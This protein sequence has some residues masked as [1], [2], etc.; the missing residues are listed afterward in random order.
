METNLPSESLL[1]VRDLGV[2][3]GN[4]RI[5]VLSG[6][7]FQLGAG[8]TLG[9]VG[10]SGCGKST[11]AMALVQLLAGGARLTGGR[12]DFD[13]QELTALPEKAL[14]R[15][16]GKDIA[17]I[18]QDP[19]SSLNPLLRIGTQ[20]AEVPRRH[21]GMDGRS[22]WRRA[23]ELLTSVRL[24]EPEARLKEYP[25]QLSGGMRQRVAGAIALAAMPKLL[26]ADEPTTALDPTVQIQYL[27][28]LKE[29]QREHGFA[30]ILITHDL[31][32]VAH[33]CDEVAVMYA[34]R[35][36][37]HGPT[38]EIFSR[39]AHPYTQALLDSLPRPGARAGDLQ[40]IGGQPPNPGRLPPGC[41]FNP[42]CPR[43]MD[44]CRVQ[45]PVLAPLPD[46]E[47]TVQAACWLHQ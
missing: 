44:K 47:S 9:I 27:K 31:G 46:T 32:I 3:Y 21:L 10:E 14:R 1:S 20:V 34:G 28:L 13:G 40:V 5:P 41:A 7:S 42:R 2:A 16:R 30:L 18:L 29:L 22:A 4:G 15:I 17:M 19:L 12:I 39:P 35:I 24:A 25:H 23:L 6:V 11:L 43:S 8:R 45:V 33:V 37:E 38:A 26:I 36:V